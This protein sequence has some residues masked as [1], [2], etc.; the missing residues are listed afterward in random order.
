MK[1]IL[2]VGFSAAPPEWRERMARM[3]EA[4]KGLNCNVRKANAPAG[5]AWAT[6][7]W[8]ER[9]EEEKDNKHTAFLPQDYTRVKA[10]YLRLKGVPPKPALCER[11]AGTG[12]F[13]W[14]SSYTKEVTTGKC[15]ACK[16]TGK[17]G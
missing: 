9:P 1:N 12:K 6:V 4:F 13:V 10:L 3:M 15:Y 2:V 17:V 16:G 7:K 14:V 8:G 11:C 5:W